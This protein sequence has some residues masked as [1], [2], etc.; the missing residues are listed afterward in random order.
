[1]DVTARVERFVRGPLP[2]AIVAVYENGALVHHVRAGREITLS[3]AED[4]ELDLDSFVENICEGCSSAREFRRREHV[5]I[6][7]LFQVEIWRPV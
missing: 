1:M 3:L 5:R 7:N 2:H 4:R 6:S